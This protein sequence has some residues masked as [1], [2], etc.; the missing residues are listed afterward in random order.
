MINYNDMFNGFW[1]ENTCS[2]GIST[3]S[4]ITV[5]RSRS[6]FRSTTFNQLASFGV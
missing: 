4:S 1:W 3:I 5:P 6:P 2:P